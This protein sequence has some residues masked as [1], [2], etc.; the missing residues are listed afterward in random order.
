[1]NELYEAIDIAYERIKKLR[2]LGTPR[3]N[4][5]ANRLTRRMNELSRQVEV[6]E[7]PS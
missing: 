2:A 3:A 7:I 6:L 4:R 1:M 5:L